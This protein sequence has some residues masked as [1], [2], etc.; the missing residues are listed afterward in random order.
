ME[1]VRNGSGGQLGDQVGD[2]SLSRGQI[3]H[4]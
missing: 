4:N 1:D 3:L 2:F